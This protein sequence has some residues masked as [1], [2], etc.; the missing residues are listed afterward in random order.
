[1]LNIPIGMAISILQIVAVGSGIIGYYL[2]Y[3]HTFAFAR[4]VALFACFAILLR[5]ETVQYFLEYSGGALLMFTALPYFLLASWTSLKRRGFYLTLVPFIF[6][7]GAF[8]KLSFVLIALSVT[9]ASVLRTFLKRDEYTRRQLLMRSATDL[10]IFLLS[11]AALYFLF[12]SKGWTATKLSLGRS[13]IETIV[14]LSY[15]LA[16]TL[17]NSLSVF[18]SVAHFGAPF[19][20][21]WQTRYLGLP[22]LVHSVPLAWL[23]F[24]VAFAVLCLFVFALVWVRVTDLEYRLLLFGLATVHIVVLTSLFLGLSLF[25]QDRHFWPVAAL[26]LPGLLSLVLHTRSTRWRYVLTMAICIQLGYAVWT[27]RLTVGRV[28]TGGRSQSL[29][30]SFPGALSGSRR[31]DTEIGQKCR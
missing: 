9:V 16:A 8:F 11:Y 3:V 15:S 23:I 5:I 31:H 30:L 10:T 2:L 27:D 25:P 28:L 7:A 26:L 4:T 22:L 19:G 17:S 1:M 14:L 21:L 12:T 20:D 29:A 18:P 6:L 13:P 24:L